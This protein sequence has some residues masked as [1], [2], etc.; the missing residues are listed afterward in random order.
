MNRELLIKEVTD[1]DNDVELLSPAGTWEALV[2][3]V[4]NGADAVYLGGKAFNARQ[5]AGNFDDE[6]LKRAVEYC[7]VRGVSVYL[8][9]NTLLNDRELKELVSFIVFANNIGIDA[10][11]VQDLGVARLIKEAVPELSLHAS[12]QMTIHNLGGVKILEKMGFDRVVLARELSY[13]EIRYICKN[14][15]LE[16]EVFVHGALCMSYSGQCLMSSLI[17]GRSGNRGCC[18][19][20]C[21]L[22]YDLVDVDSQKVLHEKLSQK[23]LL[24]PKDLS[25][26]EYLNKLKE[27]G[28]KSLK[29][30]GR[31]KRPEYVAVVT[32][33]Y[34][35]YLDSNLKVNQEDYDA[36]LQMFNR[37]GFTQN[38]FKGKTGESM[39]SYIRPNNW[40]IYIGDV[41][42]YDKKKNLVHINL[43]GNLNVGDGIEIW[44]KSGQ[45]Q[46]IIVTKLMLGPKNID[47][48]VKG[49]VVSFN[50]SGDIKKGDKV[51]KT[52]D[53]KINE[54]AK[55]TFGENVNLKK[56]PIYGHC[57]IE[58]EKPVRIS[59]WD[60]KGNYVEATGQKD[61][62]KAINKELET[63]KVLQQLNKLGGTPFDFVDISVD[64]QPG[65][66]LPVSE[67]NSVRRNAVELLVDK[68]INN[69]KRQPVQ[70]AEAKYRIEQLVNKDNLVIQNAGKIKLGAQVNSYLQAKEL[71]N[72][73]LER[74]YITANA[75]LEHK[76]QEN[77]K[78]IILQ[79]I[80]QEIEIVCVFPR[81]LLE[82]DIKVYRQIVDLI[83]QLGINSVMLGNIGHTVLLG[84]GSSYNLY[85]DFS[86]NMFNSLSIY[87][88]GELGFKC[89]T[90]SPELTFK[91]I[92]NIQKPM[93]LESE[94]LVYGRLPLMI[95][96]NCPIGSYSRYLDSSCKCCCDM[97]GYGLRDRKGIVFPLMT[98]KFTC[99]TEILNSQPLFL[100]DKMDD[101]LS[102]GINSIRLLFTNESPAECKKIASIYKDAMEMGQ[103]KA[104]EKH[105]DFIEKIMK[106][107]FTRGH[108]YKGVE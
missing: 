30:E 37:G 55:Q 21:R 58:L 56:I 64:I 4:Q 72:S 53:V 13:E 74:I 48:A 26:I 92:N 35:H 3:A 70:V 84:E 44:T 100:V 34:R 54:E 24:S 80:S 106:E 11:I 57:K 49:Q 10:V 32:R 15:S 52:S 40:G 97:K 45:D 16:V 75:L 105:G 96:Q 101:I 31:M 17:G 51:Y 29:I 22:P 25:L 87:T 82:R 9:V 76:D 59:L 86:L 43:E 8:T 69:F 63:D 38:Y 20:P 91:Q 93:A 60:D 89:V 83:G 14:S 81:I 27:V 107:G 41:V 94:I 1:L 33:I 19:Q 71:L 39:M 47:S 23:Y 6:Q 68:R 2:A 95:M 73:G 62:E 61:A 108:Y 28:V 7:H 102:S 99:R 18:A 42:S 77:F 103:D 65:L 36:L 90:L 79:Y 46:G 88:A 67:I 85:G 78:D 50:I 104:M 12:T 98:N 5:Y 66:A